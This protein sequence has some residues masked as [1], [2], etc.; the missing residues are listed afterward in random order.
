MQYGITPVTAYCVSQQSKH[1][2]PGY[3]LYYNI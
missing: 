2:G 3:T 1:T